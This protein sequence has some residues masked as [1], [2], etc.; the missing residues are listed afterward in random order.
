MSDRLRTTLS[1]GLLVVM[2]AAMLTLILTNP[3]DPDRVQAIGER[4]KCPVCQGESIANSPSAMAQD[5]MALVAERVD[6]GVSDDEIVAELLASYSGAVL[7]DPPV[8]GA[9]L[10]LWLVPVVA[11]ILGVAV[12][13]WWRRHPSPEPA[14][15][16]GD[17]ATSGGRLA[18]LLILGATLAVAVVVAGFF[19]QEREGPNEGV[20][21]LG[22][23][24]LD[25]VSNET[26]EAVIAAN[27]DNPQVDGMRLALAERYYEEGDFR[28]AFP[29]YLEVA[30][31][32]NATDTQVATSLI[33]LGWMAWEGNAEAETA[34]GLFDQ[35]LEI[36]PG[37]DT[38]RY[39]K[40]QVLWCGSD[41]PEQAASL[42]E[43]VLADPDLSADSRTQV[44]SDLAAIESGETC[45]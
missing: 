27:A 41:A 29:H 18:P 28:S 10:A 44:E 20:A 17:A 38:A 16:D 40:A 2:A 22:A 19:I 32:E 4:I 12:I 37:S 14:S 23:Q 5:M 26:M 21:N 39:L 42:L 31:S 45:T 33:R 9:T 34:T 6:Q 25:D 11:V 24:D 3:S 15:E 8:G 36:D 43:E 1:I 7:L 35:A 13:W 30:G